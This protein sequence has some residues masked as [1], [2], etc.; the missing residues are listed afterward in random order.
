MSTPTKMSE[1]NTSLEKKPVRVKSTKSSSADK[2][3]KNMKRKHEEV[4]VN[5]SK[6]EEVTQS[7]EVKNDGF[8]IFYFCLKS[9]QF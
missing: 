3:P 9:L 8:F 2:S 5:D 7:E 1:K 6:S 4:D